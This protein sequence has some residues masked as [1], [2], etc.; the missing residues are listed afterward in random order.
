MQVFRRLLLRLPPIARRDERIKDL[1]RKNYRLRRTLREGPP[2][3]DIPKAPKPSYRAM[4]HVERRIT[5]LGRPET[6]VIGLGKFE[7]QD[8]VRSHGIDVPRRF[9]RWDRLE[10]IGWDELPGR[11]VIKS[12]RGSSSRGVLPL[13]RADG[14]WQ[15]ISHDGEV[16]TDQQ[17]SAILAT[18]AETGR[19][20]GPFGAEEFID[21]DGTGA[22]TP[23]DVKVYTF[24][25][26]AP[27]VLIRRVFKH[28]D[29]G[30]TFR[31]IDRHGH[32]IG[33]IYSGKPIDQTME[34]PP[35][36]A[37]TVE[38][39]ER[40]SRA[41][42]APFSRLDFYNTDDRI[43]FGEVTPR[44]GGPQWFGPDLDAV[45]GDAWERARARYARDIADGMSPEFQWGSALD[46]TR[47]ESR[48]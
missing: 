26:D 48:P 45:L 5:E 11:V 1:K 29:P 12:R 21:E 30:A 36:L 47:E 41:I 15:I 17:V 14:G 38:I 10:D 9:G 4:M 18:Q 33:D 23:M 22:H 20:E 39:A 25:G 19:I 27:M 42:R 34:P 31:I 43:V 24:Y 32:D 16:L 44:P 37:E 3:A 13:R 40:L 2:P 35:R 46:G 8:L 6:S 28:G 7:V